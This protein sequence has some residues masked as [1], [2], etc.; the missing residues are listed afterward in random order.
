M[1]MHSSLQLHRI[2]PISDTATCATVKFH[3]EQATPTW[4]IPVSSEIYVPD[5]V[6]HHHTHAVA[7]NQCSSSVVQAID[8]PVATV[9][10]VV[11][12]FDKPHAYKHFLKSCHVMGDGNVGT[13][14]EV[15]VVSG[16]PAASSTERLE[17]LDDEKH[18]MSFSVV[19]G[20][21]R[22]HNYRSVTTLHATPPP[23]GGAGN[24]GTVV[25][26]SYAVD[27]PQGNTNEETCAFV[28]TIVRCNLQSL[29]QIAESLAKD[30]NKSS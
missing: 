6:L 23:S 22:L 18:V 4:V 30:S 13:L 15:L 26:E 11:R 7:P 17:I 1:E 21:H 25:V 9:W 24:H 29:A 19:G 27:I 14:R 20:D 10:S 8:A 2:N 28:D 3:H 16:L 12:R 5:I